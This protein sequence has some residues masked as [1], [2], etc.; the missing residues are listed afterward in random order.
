MTD[1]PDLHALAN[2]PMTAPTA[3]RF[4]LQPR[5]GVCPW[6]DEAKD[7][8]GWGAGETGEAVPICEDCEA[9]GEYA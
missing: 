3:S 7:L 4:K 1:K 8:V 2:A 5:F 9:N 6:C